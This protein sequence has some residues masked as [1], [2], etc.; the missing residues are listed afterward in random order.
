MDVCIW[1]EDGDGGYSTSCGKAFIINDGTPEENGMNYCPFCGKPLM[2][3]VF[4]EEE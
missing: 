4:K 1:M 2:Q 3:E